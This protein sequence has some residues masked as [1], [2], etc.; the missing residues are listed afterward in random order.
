VKTYSFY[1]NYY[2]FIFGPGGP[3]LSQP[4]SGPTHRWNPRA[5]INYQITPDILLYASYSTGFT[6][7]GLNGR[8]LHPTGAFPF[9][10]E[11]IKAYEAGFK[12]EWLDH[13]LRLNADVFFTKYNNIQTTLLGG[14]TCNCAHPDQIFYVDNGGTAHIKGFE[15]ELEARPVPD[16]MIQ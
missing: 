4:T 6:A 1:R 9:G 10:P 16:W 2:F 7:G 3:R 11:D 8:P 13:R 12:S 14:P 15:A 5:A